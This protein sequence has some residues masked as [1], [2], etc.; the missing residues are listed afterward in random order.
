M[1]GGSD[2]VEHGMDSVVPEARVTLD[3]RLLGQ[4]VIVLPLQVSDNLRK[5]AESQQ[6]YSSLMPWRCVL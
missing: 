5:A 6:C 3:A 2:E 1:T 4:D